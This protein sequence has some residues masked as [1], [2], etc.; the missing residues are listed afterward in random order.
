M[1]ELTTE[2]LG[3]ACRLFMERAY[4]G[5]P[6]TIPSK[7]RPYFTIAAETPLQD[8]LPP[9]PVATGI[10]ADL[11]AKKQG[12][13]GYEL[14]LGSTHF[15]HLKLRV[16]RVE[17]RG[18]QLWIYSVDTHDAFSPSHYLPPAD[19]PDAIAWRQLQEKNA[20]L[21]QHIEEALE[22]AGFLTFK[23][24]LRLGLSPNPA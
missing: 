10:V 13:Q 17:D 24:L 3:R 20:Q 21:K 12:Q 15:P 16:H 19:H 14:R 23:S 4:P 7:K 11:A 1:S 8:Y 18:Q 22:S 2:R 6:E 9:T 5:G